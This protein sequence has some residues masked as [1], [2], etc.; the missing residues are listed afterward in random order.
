[1]YH[2]H[3]LSQYS[4]ETENKLSNKMFQGKREMFISSITIAALG[5]NSLVNEL[6][7]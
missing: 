3:V 4:K 2:L 1:M 5:N 6:I 7:A